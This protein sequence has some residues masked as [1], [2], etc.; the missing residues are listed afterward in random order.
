MSKKIAIIGSGSWGV[1]IS[2][3]L[4]N[5]GYDPYIWSFD[6]NEAKNINEK[7]ECIF[8]PGIKL[9]ENI[10]CSTNFEEVIPDSKFILVVTP[11]KFFRATIQKFKHLVKP[12]QHIV[13]CSK[14]LEDGTLKTLSEVAEDELPLNKVG[15]L[16]GPSHAEEVARNLPTTIVLCSKYDELL[17][18]LQDMFMSPVF[19]V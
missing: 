15:I 19:R 18:D 12:D 6:E 9:H 1:G 10:K 5:N 7:R 4:N 14:G 8:L 17:E 13:I 16:S 11:S 2:I 3:L